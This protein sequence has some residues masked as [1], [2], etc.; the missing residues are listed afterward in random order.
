MYCYMMLVKL[1]PGR[2]N[3]SYVQPWTMFYGTFGRTNKTVAGGPRAIIGFMVLEIMTR[4][5]RLV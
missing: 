3:G 2:S 5:K 1:F 4:T